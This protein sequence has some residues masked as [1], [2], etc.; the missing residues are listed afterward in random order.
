MDAIG[1]IG[2][3]NMGRALVKGIKNCFG[4]SKI[5]FHRASKE[6]MIEFAKNEEIEYALS[7]TDVV[8]KAK[9]I[10]LAVKPQMFDMIFDEINPYITK[11]KVVISLAPG[12]TIAN[13]KEKCSQGRIVRTMP[14][15]PAMVGEGMTGICYDEAEFSEEEISDIN[16]IFESVGKAKK[17]DEKLINSVVCASGS[18]PAYVFMFMEAL[19]DGAVKCGM[20]R[21]MAY[22]F[23]AQAVLGS[24]KLMQETGMHPGELKDMVCSPG[25]TTIAGVEELEKNGFRKA[26]FKATDA[27]YEKCNSI[28]EKK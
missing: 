14:N 16:K 12:I 27:C 11:E 17:V 6:K 8:K 20:P 26:V 5:I 19:A 28:K 22:E 23:V 15:T 25:G 10:I 9:Y 1:F 13:L 21:N 18:S 3:G 2:M 24:A 4:N 7:N